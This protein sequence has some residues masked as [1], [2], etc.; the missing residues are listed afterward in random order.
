MAPYLSFEQF[1]FVSVFLLIA[2]VLSWSTQLDM[3]RAILWATFRTVVQLFALGYALLWIF[4]QNNPYLVMVIFVFMTIFAGQAIAERRDSQNSNN[5]IGFGLYFY[6][7]F[8]SIFFSGALILFLVNNLVIQNE[9]W[10]NAKIFIPLAG[11]ILGNAMNGIALAMNS[12]LR[13]MQTQQDKIFTM[14]CYGATLKEATVD[15]RKQAIHQALIP[16]I[17]AMLSVGIVFI[18]GMMTG[19]LLGGAKPVQAAMYQIIVMLM[20]LAVVL[21]GSICALVLL[22]RHFQKV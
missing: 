1:S 19:Q 3:G 13:E 20:L 8:V 9:P 17:N 4:A 16:Q 21:L 12:Y 5:R 15:I 10:Y 18:P 14:L 2:L 6:I 7:S 11:M 22:Q